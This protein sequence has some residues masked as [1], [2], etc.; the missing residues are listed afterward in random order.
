MWVV[1]VVNG[2]ALVA[3]ERGG[4]HLVLGGV[5]HLGFDLVVDLL[6]LIDPALR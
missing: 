2:L 1:E 5:Y 6:F 3:G 4:E